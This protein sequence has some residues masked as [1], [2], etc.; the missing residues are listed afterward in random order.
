MDQWG[1]HLVSC[2]LSQPQ[3]RHN[4]LRDALADGL[5][6]HGIQTVKEV[7]IGGNRRPADIGLPSFDA[8][9]PVA[10]DLVV[11]HP[12]SLSQNWAAESIRASL[13]GAEEQKLRESE[14]LCHG[15]GWL[16]S[17]MGW[18]PW[19][20]VGP[21][22]SALRA[23]LEK[24]IAGDLQGW[25]RRH[26]IQAFRARLTFAL[27]AFVARQL[28][29]SE[30]ALLGGVEEGPMPPFRGGAVFA[31]AE[32][33]NWEKDEEEETMVGPIRVR[34][35]VARPVKQAGAQAPGTARSGVAGSQQ[36]ADSVSSSHS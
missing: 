16:F 13:K 34:V 2:K 1:D 24:Q 33:A 21:H 17:P 27:M 32:L 22:G 8:R 30:D 9:G 36:P 29:A 5:L 14:D 19:A 10:V 12:L 4:A 20:G 25:P 18:H 26:V 28:R 11:H 31:T 23:R 15:N 6:S 7:A 35:K 3:Q